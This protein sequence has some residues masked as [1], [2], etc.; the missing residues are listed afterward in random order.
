[1]SPER[2]VAELLAEYFR[3]AGITHVY[4]YPGESL[5]DFIE[6]ARQAGPLPAMASDPG[7]DE[8]RRAASARPPWARTTR[9]V[10]S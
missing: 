3:Q 7:W 10:I 5:V 8:H 1:M 9:A 2:T 4:G 6:A